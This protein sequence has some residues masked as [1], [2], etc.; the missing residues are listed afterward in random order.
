VQGVILVG[1]ATAIVA[2]N[3]DIAIWAVS[4]LG[5]SKRTL[6]ARLG[7]AYPLAR[8]FRTSMLLGMYAIVVFTLTFLSVFSNLFS[9]QA[10]QFAHDTAAGYDVLVDSNFSNPVPVNALTSQPEVVAEA[11]IDRAFPYWKIPSR[12]DKEPERW[13]LSGFD[14]ALFA[15][16]VPALDSRDQKYS[17]DRA[18]WDAVLHD[19]SL[20]ILSD[21]FLQ[22]GGPPEGRLDVGDKVI[23]TDTLTNHTAELTIA[24]KVGS[25][26]TFLGPMVGKT[27][28]H[29]FSTDV[30]PSRHYVALK[31]G[32]DPREFASK[33]EGRLLSY[34]VEAATFKDKI[35]EALSQQ[36]GFLSLMR[37]YLGLGLVIGIAGLGVVMVR[38]VRE[39]RREIGMLRA[40]GFPGRM[41]RQAFLTEASFLAVQGIVLGTVL[42]LVTAYNLL[43]HSS[44]FGGQSIDFHIPWIP[45]LVVSSIALVA[46][47][48]A[49]AAPAAQAS[50]IKPAV[51]LR[52]AD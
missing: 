36:Q 27:F 3:D 28:L 42:A 22:R 5:V 32:V 26:F 24:A 33:L 6:A 29:S 18:A 51:A 17:S 41:V 9:A 23:A 48:L 10:P 46:S 21:F 19:P 43:T 13:N 2:T 20:V 40:M 30:T 1:S 37:G 7:F 11:T 49:A 25:D 34:G 15:R 50:R 31:P 45:I 52:I 35:S 8:V 4:K 16:G 38:A 44:T 39:R 12:P 14:E 47:L